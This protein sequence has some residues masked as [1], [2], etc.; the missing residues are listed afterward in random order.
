MQTGFCG[1]GGGGESDGEELQSM[2]LTIISQCLR[3]SLV[4]L[5][6]LPL[7]RIIQDSSAVTKSTVLSNL[8]QSRGWAFCYVLDVFEIYLNFYE[9]KFVVK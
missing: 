6:L 8:N 9:S 2:S 7:E 4:P 3:F 5:I 1:G